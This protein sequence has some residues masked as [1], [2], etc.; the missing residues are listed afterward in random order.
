MARN[1]TIVIKESEET[2]VCL[3]REVG[4]YKSALR[5]Q[6][7]IYLKSNPDARYGSIAEKM[8]ISQRTLQGW[9]SAYMKKG[10][11]DYLAPETRNRSSKIITAEA[12]D[13]LASRLQDE[14]N[15]FSGYVEV[16]Q[17]LKE[18][19]DI[20]I[21][22]HWLRKYMRSKFNSRLKVPRKVNIKKQPGAEE[23]FFKIAGGA[24]TY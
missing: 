3:K 10:I 15:P 13:A 4:N 12:H 17:W 8:D 14:H 2:L 24:Q 16:Q 23:S 5:L 21:E 11:S 9:L 7:L 1:R 6:A 18:T 22:Y 20:T 19:F